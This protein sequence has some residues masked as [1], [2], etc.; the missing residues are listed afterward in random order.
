MRLAVKWNNGWAYAHGTGPDGR[1]IRRSLKTKD[2]RRAE[3]LRTQLESRL[4]EAKLYG[5]TKT[6]SFE[7]CA[8]AYAEDGGETRFLYKIAKE[9]NGF[10]LSDITPK[11]IRDAAKKAYPNAKASTLNRQGIV[12]AQAV[13]NYGHNEGWCP[14]IRV[15]GFPVEKPIRQAVDREY[16]DTLRPHIPERA[17]AVLLFLHQTGR[18]IG[19]ALTLTPSQL[20]NGVV[21]IPKTKNGEAVT[22]RLT[23]E[24]QGLIEA[25]EPR[26]GLLFG[27]KARSSLYPTLRRGCKK[28]GIPYLG[29]HQPGR[30]SFA[31]SLKNA[32]WSSKQVAEAGGWKT[33]RLID[34]TYEHPTEAQA[35]SASFFD[36]KMAKD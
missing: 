8:L 24:A 19:D 3:E 33:T 7:Q 5:A 29:T 32:G 27:Y 9:L 18:R 13:I 10:R 34:E 23:D 20:S 2:P 12:P 31:T 15:R 30:H 6:V 35:A 22:L 21:R 17:F 26:H 25:I 11:T 4:W 16:I 36:K 28:A 14:P 1:R